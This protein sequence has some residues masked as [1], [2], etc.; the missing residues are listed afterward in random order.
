MYQ[1]SFLLF[2]KTGLIVVWRCSVNFGVRQGSVLSP[3][4][5]FLFISGWCC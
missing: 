5:L 3:F 4:L 1:L 2:L